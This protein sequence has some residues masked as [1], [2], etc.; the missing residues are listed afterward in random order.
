MN[1]FVGSEDIVTPR[2]FK[3]ILKWIDNVIL[4]KPDDLRLF[5]KH[6]D[7]LDWAHEVYLAS[8]YLGIHSKFSN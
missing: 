6:E 3:V 8:E 1:E 2:A 7:F 5:R 4:L